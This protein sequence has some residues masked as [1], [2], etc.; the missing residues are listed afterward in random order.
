MKNQII[1]ILKRNKIKCF[2]ETEEAQEDNEQDFMIPVK[3]RKVAE[4][5][6]EEIG[7][8]DP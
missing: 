6:E 8:N 7:A 1:Q 5:I 4:L 2:Q 3:R